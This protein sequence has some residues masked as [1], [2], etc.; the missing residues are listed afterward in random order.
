MPWFGGVR[1]CGIAIAYLLCCLYFHHRSKSHLFHAL[2][3]H[4]AVESSQHIHRLGVC[5]QAIW[6]KDNIFHADRFLIKP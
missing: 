6:A 5:A 1:F 2:T 4:P 3:L